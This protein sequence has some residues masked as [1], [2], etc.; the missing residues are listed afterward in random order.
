MSLQRKRIVILGAGYAGMMAALRLSGKTEKQNTEIVL[1]NGSDT[2]VQRPRLHHTATGQ[3]VPEEPL[4]RM[5]KGSRVLFLQGR[6]TA[7]DPDAHTVA[8]QTGSGSEKIAYDILVYA[9]GSVVDQESVP[10]VRDHAYVLDPGGANGARAMHRR[11]QALDESG[12]RIVVVG[13]GATGIEGATEIKG[14]Y[15]GVDV[16]VVTSGRFAAFKGPRVEAHIRDAFRKQH[17]TVYEGRKVAA[18]EAGRL[19]LAGGETLPFDVCLWAGGF[20]A[21]PLAREAGFRVNERGQIVV[22]PF[23]RSLSHGDVYAIGDAAHAVEAPGVPLRM[24]LLTAVIRGAHAAD[25][26]AALLKGEE[27]TPLS[28][29]YYGQGIALGPEDAV[30]FLAYPADEPVG[31]ILR[32]KTA[33][34]VRN[35]F[36]WLL[37]YFLKLERQRP[38]FFFW[39]GKER[40]AKV[41]QASGQWEAVGSER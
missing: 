19:V 1:V 14:Q 4:A 7:V 16:S 21:L 32:G 31:F 28:F 36:V 25:N 18:V 5:L 22:D 8:V 6:V 9:L 15:L 11:M 33:V 26:I 29:A 2:F 24:S 23:G 39:L 10:G 12:A 34:Y 13:G 40:Y 35:F 38:G 37:F 27:Q 3:E 30:G 20:R 41:R 17:I